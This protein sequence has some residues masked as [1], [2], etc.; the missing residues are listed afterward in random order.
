MWWRGAMVYGPHV[1]S[2]F[3][4]VVRRL[5]PSWRGFRQIAVRI[6]QCN[7]IFV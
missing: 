2:P 3:T 1:G 6:E 5:G 7:N 4:L